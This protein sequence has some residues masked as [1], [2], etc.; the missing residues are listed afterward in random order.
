MTDPL[1]ELLAVAGVRGSLISRAQLSPPW[2]IAS[3]SLPRAVFHTPT[4]GQAWLSL[5]GEAP[6][7][8]G[9]GDV[10][11][12]PR[13]HAHEIRDAPGRRCRPL[14]AHEVISGPEQLP[15]V[16]NGGDPIALDLLCG[17]FEL[18]AP[19][20]TWLLDPLPELFV[21]RGA[22]QASQLV[23]ATLGLLEAELATGGLG[24]RLVSDRLVEVLV[25]HLLRAWAR[26]ESP[27]AR[28]WLAGL[29]DPHLGRLIAAIHA[30]PTGDW[31]LAAMAKRSGLS[32]TRF[33]ARFRDRI[34]VAPGTWVTQWRIAVARRALREGAD[35]ARAAEQA[36]YASEA[37]FSR[38][39]K[40][41]VGQPPG[42][43]RRQLT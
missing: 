6:L 2:G 5:P 30:E 21:V 42:T 32:R 25:V 36:G 41:I 43:W 35:V 4:R 8:L 14:A 33:V 22:P 27:D 37:S 26:A 17:S 10:A 11:V 39:F 29:S 24:A 31:S 23:E 16:T 3:T 38:A 9:P 34:G 40:R 19:A 12:L 18:G 13:G 15:T 20:A 1:S 7:L 28:G